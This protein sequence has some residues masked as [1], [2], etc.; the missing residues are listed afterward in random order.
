[1]TQGRKNVKDRFKEKK[2]WIVLGL[3]ALFYILS[4]F[5]GFGYLTYNDT[6]ITCLHIP[7]ILVTLLMGLPEGFIVALFFGLSSMFSAALQP[8]DSIDYL[9]RNPALSVIPRLMIPFVVWGVNRLIRS[10]IDD[11][12]KSAN[13]ICVAFAGLGGVLSNTVSVVFALIIL[14]PGNIG[15]NDGFSAG[16]TIVSSILGANIL[17]EVFLTL[18]ATHLIYYIIEKLTMK[19]YTENKVSKSIKKTFQ[20]WLLMIN[21]L[22]FVV[23]FF[24]LYV[25]LTYD[26][27][28]G[29]INLLEEKV[30]ATAGLIQN[31]ENVIEDEGLIVGDHGF[32]IVCKDN[33]VVRCGN[34][35]LV[36]K[37][38]DETGFVVNSYEVDDPEEVNP[39]MA[40][41]NGISGVL[42]KRVAG[43]YVVGAFL[44]LAEVYATRN[45]IITVLLCGLVVLYLILYYAVT[46]L[47]Q[48]RVVNRIRNINK[49]LASIR[50]GNLDEVVDVGGNVEFEKLSNGINAT[51][52]A[53]KD[54][55]NKIEEKTRQEKEFARDIQYAALPNPELFQPEGGAYSIWATM[56]TAEE[57]GGDFFDIYKLD[58]GRLGMVVAD[59]SGKGVP[60]A[61]FMMTSKTILKDLILSGKSPAE[62]LEKANA[63]LGENNEKGMFVTTW[64]GIYDPAKHT[65]EFANAGHNPPVLKRAGQSAEYMDYKKYNRSLMLGFIPGTTYKDDKIDFNPGD[66]LYLYTDGVTEARNADKEFYGEARLLECITAHSEENPKELLASIKADVDTFV[67]GAEQSDDITMVALK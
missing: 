37:N 20:K 63:Q 19:D 31:S 42:S 34:T 48:N 44:P 54:T 10:R 59:V 64:L 25:L 26:N 46:Y 52:S 49:S 60:A 50:R 28:M 30:N 53:L 9:F 23:T 58:D 33:M 4:Y 62:A 16:V 40:K 45:Q 24:F 47:I 11:G 7:V 67:N 66:M 21:S 12:T 39:F 5:W 56:D 14:Y 57:V 17:C 2:T 65:L 36:G 51:V 35:D 18:F 55:M 22:F 61:L 3:L 13:Y 43:E 41:Y 29:Y 1:M 8:A 15:I 27:S 6:S 38:F 32:V